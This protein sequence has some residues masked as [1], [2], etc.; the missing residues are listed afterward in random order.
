MTSY[1][2]TLDALKP[3]ERWPQVRKWIFAQDRAFYEEL[4]NEEPLLR[5]PELTIASRFVDCDEILR[6][7]DRFSVALYQP[8]QGSY[9]MAQD[10][11]AQHWREKSIMKCVL[12]FE[13]VPKIRAFVAERAKSLLAA[14][15]GEID[16]VDGLTRAAPIAVVQE[17]FGYT[18]SNPDDLRAWS[19]W[20]QMDT[21][22]N[23][24]FDLNPNAAQITANR[25]AGNLALGKYIVGLVQQRG[26]ELRA[27][28]KRDDPVTR[29]ILLANCGGLHDFPPERLILNIGGLLIG[30]VETTSH[31]AVNVMDFFLKNPELLKDATEAAADSDPTKLDGHVFEALRFRPAFPYFFRTVTTPTALGRGLDY[32]D[33]FQPGETVFALTHSAMFDEMAF[34][35]P[36]AFD[37]TRG[38]T[39]CFHFGLDMHECLGRA[40][41]SVMIPEIVRQALL[42]KDLKTDAID[43]KGG[44]VPESWKWRW[45]A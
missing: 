14:A 28:V 13:D 6:R 35:D 15:K 38:M 3:E 18:D 34:T 40:I 7:Y 5:L 21:F 31:A 2:D 43:Q 12:D 41:G 45:S 27:G 32:E 19:Y 10:D 30:A 42:L 8:K 39:N 20:S 4:R 26:T 17:W 23:Q 24:S 44:P 16:A 9:F 33:E 29:L 1:L 11:T 25:E 36:D 37:P 22:W